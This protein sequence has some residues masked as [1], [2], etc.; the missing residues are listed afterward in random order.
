MN[1]FYTSY[2]A[3]VRKKPK[4]PTFLADNATVSFNMTSYNLS[5][6]ADVDQS[7]NQYAFISNMTIARLLQYLE[8]IKRIHK[9]L[10]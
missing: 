5:I 9:N 6:C 7:I 4:S 2:T 1:N 3:D 8:V 10:H